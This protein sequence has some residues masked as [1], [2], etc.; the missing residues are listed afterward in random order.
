LQ[1]TKKHSE[2]YP[3]FEQRKHKCGKPEHS[4]ALSVKDDVVEESD[5]ILV[6][7]AVY[8]TG[9]ELDTLL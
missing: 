7:A 3:S 5:V 4:R 8:F 1:A 2:A 9:L 6:S